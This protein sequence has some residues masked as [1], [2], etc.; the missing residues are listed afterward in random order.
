MPS[1]ETT[2]SLAARGHPGT[3]HWPWDG[4]TELE[5]PMLQDFKALVSPC[6]L[7]LSRWQRFG[8]PS[9]NNT[10][11]RCT[12]HQAQ[13]Q[14][15]HLFYEET[16]CRRPL[17]NRG[18]WRS[19]L[20]A[21]QRSSAPSFPRAPLLNVRAAARAQPQFV[22]QHEPQSSTPDLQRQLRSSLR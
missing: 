16:R 5:E 13:S 19:Q 11:M 1:F 3:G 9:L 17:T 7:E 21:R 14:K 8:C 12:R 15:E 6:A 18:C 2:P 20:R 4:T 22:F 10:C